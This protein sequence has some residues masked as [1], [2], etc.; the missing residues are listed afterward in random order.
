MTNF[1]ENFKQVLERKLRGVQLE[2]VSGDIHFGKNKKAWKSFKEAFNPKVKVP[3]YLETSRELY[4][5]GEHIIS[6]IKFGLFGAESPNPRWVEPTKEEREKEWAERELIHER[7][8]ILLWEMVA[9]GLFSFDREKVQ[10]IFHSR[11][12][13][14]DYFYGR[15]LT[16]FSEAEVKKA[17][18]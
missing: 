7:V 4:E 16:M 9:K 5:T 17:E 15:A 14:W 1:W 2:D 18:G 3:D 11:G 8:A 12:Y 10:A 6:G 13:D